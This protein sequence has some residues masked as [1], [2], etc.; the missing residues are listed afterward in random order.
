[1]PPLVTRGN[2]ERRL[3]MKRKYS[4]RFL[5]VL[6]LFA[7][8]MLFS[9]AD[10]CAA[11]Q[12]RETDVSTA[13]SGNGIVLVEGTFNYLP[14]EDI[15]ARINEIRK[16]ACDEGVPRP[17][18]PSQRLSSSDYVPIRWSSDLEWIAQTRAAEATVHMDHSRPN[19]GSCFGV[20]H[21][22]NKSYAEDLAWNSNANIIGGINK[23]Y[24]EKDDWVNQNKDAVT[25]HYTSIINPNYKYIGIG[26]FN[27]SGRY[28]AVAGELSAVSGL[29]ETQNG[30]QGVYKQKME[31]RLSALTIDPDESVAAHIGEEAAFKMNASTS[32]ANDLGPYWS[33]VVAGVTLQD[34]SYS[35]GDGSI[36]SVTS[37]G[38]ISGLKAGKTTLTAE[39]GGTSYEAE[40]TVGDHLWEEI[41]KTEATCTEAGSAAYECTS[42]GETKTED[43]PALGHA[44]DQEYTADKTATCTEDGEE[45]IHCSRCDATKD[46]RTVAAKGHKWN[47]AYTVDKASTCTE[48]GSESIHCSVCDAIKEDTSR[49]IQKKAHTYGSWKTT[50]E[51]KCTEN[52][53]REKVCSVCSDK[54]I[55]EIPALGHAW[56]QEYTADTP[57]TCTESGTESIHCSRCDATKDERPIPAKDHRW[58]PNYTVDKKATYA[59]KG[60]KSIHCSECNAV[61]PGSAAAIPKLTVKPAALSS[62]TAASKGFTA[63]WK[64]GSDVTG[65]Q[66]QYA[67]NSKFTSGRKIIT[68]KKATIVSQKVTKL[69]AKKRYYVRVRAYRTY[70]G[71]NYYSAWSKARSVATK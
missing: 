45:S 11:D 66:L 38:V 17:G 47:E 15:L 51:E 8:L 71:K 16:E 54:V 31:V 27:P 57:A 41:S 2:Y 29:D 25:G 14:K 63:K 33:P 44:W 21:G 9:G 3:K 56:N 70:K 58:K 53:S 48:E 43:T 62:L 5:S 61:K 10:I 13:A 37:D 36:A 24:E 68:V 34:V 55:E 30:A 12:I 60:S 20:V 42:C 28:G 39:C 22:G 64:K 4:N 50:K 19:G 40:L 52:G 65:Y 18:N 59:E 1:M 49:T 69:R 26:A 23:W 32:Y 7:G 6:V 67:L 46:K 35:V